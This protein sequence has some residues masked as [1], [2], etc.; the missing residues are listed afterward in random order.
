MVRVKYYKTVNSRDRLVN[1]R[2]F[3]TAEQAIESAE[4]WEGRTIDNYAVFAYMICPNT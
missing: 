2:E 4:E 1:E 3:E